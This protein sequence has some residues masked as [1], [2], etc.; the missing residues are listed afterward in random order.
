MADPFITPLG[1]ENTIYRDET[2]FD[3]N[4]KIA[5]DFAEMELIAI[6][7]ESETSSIFH[8]NYNGKPRVLKVFHNNKDPGYANDGV[9]DLNRTRC[10]IRAYCSLKRFKIC[11]GGFVPKFYGYMLAVNPTS[12]EPHLD[13]FQHDIDLPSAILIEYLPNPVPMN[14]VTYS[15]KRFE[16]VNIGIRQIHLALIEHNDPYPKNVLIVPGDPERVV[17]IDFD[18]AIVYPNETYI[19]ERERGWI[20]FE[21]RCVESCGLKLEKDQKDGLSPNSK[22]Y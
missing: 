13:A 19:G 6:L 2:G 1:P 5:I 11:D 18:V 12:W 3:E 21:T 16:K 15:K 9:R 4:F 14:S 7:K 20:E 22:Y 17:W 10:E 8:V